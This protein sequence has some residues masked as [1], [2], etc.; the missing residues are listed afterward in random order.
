MGWVCRMWRKEAIWPQCK[1]CSGKPL[2]LSSLGR[3]LSI[4]A[5]LSFRL[6]DTERFR[7]LNFLLSRCCNTIIVPQAI[8]IAINA[9]KRLFLRLH[10]AVFG[11]CIICLMLI[12]LSLE[13][14]LLR[15]ALKQVYGYMELMDIFI[16]NKYI[17]VYFNSTVLGPSS[18]KKKKDPQQESENQRHSVNITQL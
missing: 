18:P 16:L 9:N 7:Q 1:W 14:L 3:F 4:S 6:L 10:F 13:R 2:V 5:C 11:S 17:F 8:C 12:H 15:S